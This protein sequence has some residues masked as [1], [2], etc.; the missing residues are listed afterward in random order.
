MQIVQLPPTQIYVAGQEGDENTENTDA[1]AYLDMP[2]TQISVNNATP[3]GTPN[4][5]NLGNNGDKTP[6]TP[7]TPAT[8]I[9][10][11]DNGNT[12]VTP[13]TVIGRC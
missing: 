7:A 1:D 9:D 11:I 5:P 4:P 10:T 12:P 8:A 2:L 13:A 6:V 3:P